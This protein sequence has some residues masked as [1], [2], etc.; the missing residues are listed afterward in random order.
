M[1]LETRYLDQHGD[2]KLNAVI[3]DAAISIVVLILLLICWPFYSVPTGSR[4][5]VT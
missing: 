4:G 2:V 3:R 1:S 5:V